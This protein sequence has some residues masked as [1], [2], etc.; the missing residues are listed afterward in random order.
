MFPA[1]VR[2]SPQALAFD[3]DLLWRMWAREYGRML[4][5]HNDGR[6]AE[7]VDKTRFVGPY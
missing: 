1:R 7:Q 5:T 4:L 3:A 2:Q 6:L